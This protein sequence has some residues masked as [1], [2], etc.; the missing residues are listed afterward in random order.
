M[1]ISFP[2]KAYTRPFKYSLIVKHDKQSRNHDSMIAVVK[3]YQYETL[4]RPQPSTN[5]QLK[6]N[7][8]A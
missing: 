1:P 6:L 4:A 5:L 8:K 2:A 7:L 3:V